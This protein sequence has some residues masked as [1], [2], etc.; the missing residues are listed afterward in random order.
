V[1]KDNQPPTVPSTRSAGGGGPVLLDVRPLQGPSAARGIGSYLRGLIGGLVEV[2][3]GDRLAFLTFADREPPALPAGRPVHG[4]RRRWHGQLRA[5]EDA[6]VLGF[7][8]DRI[9]PSL[10]HA[11]DFNLP[12][13]APCPVV[14]TV[15]DLIP[16][17]FGGPRMLGE[18]LRFWAGKRLLGRAELVLAVSESS[19][20]DAIR[21]G[22]VSPNR[23]KVVHEGVDP[24][25]N[26][27]ADARAEAARRWGLRRPYLVFVGALDARKDPRGLLRA[28]QVARESGA[29]VDLLLAGEAGP[30]APREMPGARRLGHLDGDELAVV[31]SAASCLLFPSRYEGFGLPVLEAMACGC[32]VVAY[33]N[34]SLPEIA[35]EAA[36]LVADGDAD[37][38]GRAAGEIV[39][40][41]RR[42]GRLREAGLRRA[43][44]FTWRK[45]AR[46]TISGYRSLLK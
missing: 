40:D 5:Y 10:Y 1:A 39:L 25:L 17:A 44:R 29:D 8:L 37:A 13:R 35:G 22:R 27:R 24:A 33:R 7:D 16:W 42:A 4:V 3:F 36:V 34:S 14:V 32:P 18:R 26:P 2:G 20:A 46:A 30:Q 9:R 45:A 6:A 41:A 43:Q 15:H 12:R 28:W 19:A 21:L 11:V 38:L 23:I 31:L